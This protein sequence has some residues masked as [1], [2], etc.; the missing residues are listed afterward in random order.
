MILND[1]SSGFHNSRDAQLVSWLKIKSEF[2]GG[3]ILLGNGFSCAVW[4]NF[5]YSSLY[6]KAC[7]GKEIEHPLSE[8]DIQLFES[9]KTKNF[10]RILYMLLNAINVNQ[11]FG[12]EYILLKERYEH[13][14]TALGEAVRAVHIPWDRVDCS[15]KQKIREELLKY[16]QIYLTNYDLLTYW[17]TMPQDDKDFKDDFK[18]FFWNRPRG[19]DEQLF[20]IA[21]T[22]IRDNPTVVLYLHGALHIYRNSQSERTYKLVNNGM[23]NILKVVEV[24]LFISEGTS[25]DK[26]R[27]INSSDYLSFAYNKFINHSGSLV[28]FGHSLDETD[29]H[30]ISAIRNSKVNKIA[31]SIRGSNTPETIKKKMADLNHKLCDKN[32][33]K[34]KLF[35]FDAETHPLGSSSI[36]VEDESYFDF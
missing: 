8:E 23:E 22:S 19:S 25:E 30:L 24:P 12:Q 18:D 27:A 5:A 10:E 17:A 13:I 3:G 4:N 34:P 9:M 16:K 7:S 11:I 1:V 35:F 15:V 28:I 36:R 26:L 31:I 2:E 32:Y 6:E 33:S 21:N 29:E 20:N 14:K